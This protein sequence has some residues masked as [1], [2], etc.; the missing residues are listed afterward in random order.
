MIEKANSPRHFQNAIQTIDL[1]H[2]CDEPIWGHSTILSVRA[3]RREK[4]MS[5]AETYEVY[6]LYAWTVTGVLIVS[7][8]MFFVLMVISA[9]YGRHQRA[10]WGPTINARLAWV[11]MEAPSPVGF[12]VVFFMSESAFEPVPLILL[13]MFMIH[14]VYRSF[15]YPFR[16]RGGRKTEPVLLSSL[17]FVFN[18]A[19]GTTNAFAITV[20]APH[21]GSAWLTDPRF[22][23]G[24]FL[25]FSGYAINHHADAV[26]RN[27]RRPGE[28]GYKIPRGGL[29]N[30]VSSPNYFGEILEWI[31]FALAAWTVPAWVFV[32]FTCA[33]LVPR[34]LTNH[35]WYQERF[36][37]Y[38]KKRRALIPRI[39]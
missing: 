4:S 16:T 36:E 10:G 5:I 28:T 20:V 37:D 9:P 18:A 12:A 24:F 2:E 29:Y 23:I 3:E 13:T 34:A 25:F 30:W 1:H 7:V 35:R 33:N 19:N 27:L 6:P 21:L 17:A 38:P 31:G 32:A 11:L 22:L 15:V 26:L 14:Y 8:I 39:L